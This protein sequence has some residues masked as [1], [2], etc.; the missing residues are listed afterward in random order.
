[1]YTLNM[2]VSTIRTKMRQEFERH[3]YVSK[4]KTADV[5]IYKSHAEFQVRTHRRPSIHRAKAHDN[6]TRDVSTGNPQ[7]LEAALTRPQVLPRRRGPQGDTTQDFHCWLPPGTF[8]TKGI[9]FALT[10]GFPVFLLYAPY[11]MLTEPSPSCRAV[12]KSRHYVHS[13]LCSGVTNGNFLN[14]FKQTNNK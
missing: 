5:L 13:K 1:M 3:R 8:T 7:L 11:A 4:L 9:L 10:A 6:L 2:P 12:T 14:F